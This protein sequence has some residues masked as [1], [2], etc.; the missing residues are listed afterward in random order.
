MI[1]KIVL[2][3]AIILPTLVKAQTIHWLTFIDTTDKNVGQI[4]KNGQEVLY[5]KFINVVN[6]ALTEKSYKPNIE[7]VKTI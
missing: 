5:D 3:L 1:K 6:A 2:L 7:K 4:D